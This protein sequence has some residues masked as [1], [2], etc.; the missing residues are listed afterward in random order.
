MV[1]LVP[2]TGSACTRPWPDI[3]LVGGE[4]TTS[5]PNSSGRWSA[6]VAKA[7]STTDTTLLA[8]AIPHT[9]SRSTTSIVGLAGVSKKNT[10]V[11][12]LSAS[13]KACGS[14]ASTVVVSIPKRGRSEEH[15]SELQS[16]MRTSYAV[17]CLKKKKRQQSQKKTYH[18]YNT[19]N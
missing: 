17:F 3:S 13:A 8:R 12:G 5:A 6:G 15:T 16:L 7:L 11:L 10:L 18:Q 19:S 9:A 1:A 4:A 2:G 14:R